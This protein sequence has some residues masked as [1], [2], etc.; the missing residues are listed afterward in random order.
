MTERSLKVIAGL[1]EL[2]RTSLRERAMDR[3]RHAVT[4]REIAPGTRLVETEL[5]AALG[6]SRGTLREALRQLEHEGLIETDERG[7]LTVRTLSTG[8]LADM[9]TVRSA[10]EGLAAAVLTTRPDVPT[11]VRRLQGAVDVLQAA[12]GSIGESIEAELHFHRLLCEL[13]GNTTLLRAWET[14]TG[15]MRMAILFAG[16]ERAVV[17][18]SAP[19]HQELVDAIATGDPHT[20]QGAVATHMRQAARTLLDSSGNPP[21]DTS[22]Q[23]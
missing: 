7:R 9:F 14:L 16:P 13:T 11:V 6:I 15:P 19:R 5:S 23:L 8:E 4:T 17:N 18:M 22:T 20:A 10:L 1:G 2:D 12:H 3:L 21:G